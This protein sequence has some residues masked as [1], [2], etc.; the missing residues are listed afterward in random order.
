MKL[1]KRWTRALAATAVVAAVLAG[2][3]AAQAVPTYTVT[4]TVTDRATGTPLP[5]ACLDL[6]QTPDRLLATRC[7]DEQG[8]YTF[9][10][11]TRTIQPRLRGQ[12]AGHAELWWPAEPDYYNADQ[13]RY[14]T[15]GSTTIKADLALTVAVGGFAGRITQPDGSPA[16]ASEVTAIAVG[17]AYWAAKAPTDSDGRYRLDN[18]PVGSYRL[19]IGPRGWASTQWLPGTGNP[20]VATVFDVT[21][22]ATT[23]VDGRYLTANT[24]YEGGTLTGV[25]TRAAT[26]APVAAACVT[27][28]SVYSG[29]D[30]A[31]ACTDAT[32]R[33]RLASLSTNLGYKLRVRA[34]GFPAH[35][36]P[37]AVDSRNGSTYFPQWNTD[38]IVDIALRA[39]GGT[40]RG[41]LTDYPGATPALTNSVRVFA[42]DNSWSAW[43][44][45]VDGRYQFDHVPPGDYRIAVKPLE[46]TL[47]YH[48]GK[49]TAAEGKIVHVA[50]G[51]VTTVDEQL[52]PPGA[53]ELRLV[54]AVTGS[55]VKACARL[56]TAQEVACGDAGTVIFPKVWA[57]GDTPDRIL[58]DPKPTHWSKDVNPVAVVSGETTRLTV[59][60]EPGAALETSVV[61]AKDGSVPPKTCVR[62]VST[63][64]LL[65][66]PTQQEPTSGGGYCS[67]SSGKIR[68]G[69]LPSGPVQLLVIPPAPYGAQW[70]TEQGGTGDQRA[71]KAYPLRVG[72]TMTAPPIRLDRGG[73][74]TGRITDRSGKAVSSCLQ[75]FGRSADLNYP[76]L[77]TCAGSSGSYT[78]ERLGPYRWPLNVD[79]QA[80]SETN[81]LAPA[82]SGN[83]TNRFDATLVQVTAGTTTAVPAIVLPPAARIRSMDVGTTAKQIGQVEVY[84]PTTG[85]RIDYGAVLGAGSTLTG[86]PAGPIVL[87]AVLTNG[88]PCWY[89]GPPIGPRTHGGLG[90]TPIVLT[91]GQVV[92]TLRLVPGETCKPVRTDIR[93]GPAVVAGTR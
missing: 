43:T 11:L 65:V 36:A 27:A 77:R 9:S 25:V 56:V 4:G 37:N 82:W 31:T 34:D 33:Y 44:E 64:K 58:V 69:P 30:A 18:L 49:A 76:P 83:A 93:T 67:D 1:S 24:A 2:A 84:Q 17:T 86:L 73:A 51:A 40:V 59:S 48:P 90:P 63:S 89:V 3:P 80:L 91:A 23:T 54:D 87:R 5:G 26:G 81:I 13:L 29:Q 8:R 19:A 52:V 39:G 46:R 74:L 41:Q 55:P 92:E 53:V 68:I 78:L 61:D 60:L 6:Y 7:A 50:D 57:T 72:Q 14:P 42:V 71:A 10:G 22:G 75:P 15:D 32:G 16:Y 85:D 28:V 20:P 45:A 79:R 35:W 70:Y 12:A 66:S 47:Q 88:T 38:K 21:P 62:P